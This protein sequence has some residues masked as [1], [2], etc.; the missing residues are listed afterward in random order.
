MMRR[1]GCDAQKQTGQD[2][3]ERRDLSRMAGPERSAPERKA[4][5]RFVNRGTGIAVSSGQAAD[6][7]AA[8]T[9]CGSAN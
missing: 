9:P 3:T 4:E 8:A 6:R 5:R 1:S 2:K 7:R